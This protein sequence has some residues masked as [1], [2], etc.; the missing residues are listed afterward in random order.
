MLLYFGIRS[1]C[2]SACS[3]ITPCS[4]LYRTLIFN[5]GVIDEDEMDLDV[6]FVQSSDGEDVSISSDSFASDSDSE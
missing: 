6:P 5:R 2:L 4:L 1:V 3:P